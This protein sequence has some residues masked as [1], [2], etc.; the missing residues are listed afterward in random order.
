VVPVIIVTVIG[1]LGAA[2]VFA[3]IA[4][5]TRRPIRIFYITSLVVLLVSFIPNIGMFTR[6]DASVPG[7]IGLMIMHV[8]AAAAAVGIMTRAVQDTAS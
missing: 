3:L 1:V 7:I 8:V 2:L 6:E 4:R 5:Y